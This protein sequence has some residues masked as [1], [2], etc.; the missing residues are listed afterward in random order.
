MAGM[1]E[2]I[3]CFFTILLMYISP[4]DLYYK[5]VDLFLYDTNFFGKVFPNRLLYS[6]MCKMF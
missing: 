6:D 4:L 1:Y 2:A 5:T 3:Y